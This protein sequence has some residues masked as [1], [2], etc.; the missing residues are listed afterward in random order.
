MYLSSDQPRSL[1]E[2]RTILPSEV[3]ALLDYKGGLERY[4]RDPSWR[5]G[6]IRHFG[7][8]LARMIDACQRRNVPIVLVNP[9]ANLLTPP[10]K[11]LPTPGLTPRKRHE[12]ARLQ[13]TALDRMS[14]SPAIAAE[15]LRRAT[16]IDHQNATLFYELGLAYQALEDQKKAVEA[17][18]QARDLDLCPL[19]ITNEMSQMIVRLATQKSVPLLDADILFRA[20]APAASLAPTGWSTTSIPRSVATNSSPTPCS[21]LWPS[22]GSRQPRPPLGQA[23][24]TPSMRPTLKA[25]LPSTSTRLRSVSKTSK[26]GPEAAL[27]APA[28]AARSPTRSSRGALRKSRALKSPTELPVTRPQEQQ[29]SG[30]GRLNDR[31]RGTPKRTAGRL[32]IT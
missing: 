23:H 16:L 29:R 9:V 28:L 17:F 26:T 1:N 32:S 15:L 4:K 6:V 18:E 2:S 3:D 19:R 7:L 22:S 27:S 5:T 31:R 14:T 21:K 30:L 10:F 13:A 24:E 20:T 12:V 11:A 25:C 8:N